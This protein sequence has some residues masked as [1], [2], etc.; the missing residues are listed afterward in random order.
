MFVYFSV[1]DLIASV[2]LVSVALVSVISYAIFVEPEKYKTRYASPTKEGLAK[3]HTK[4]YW[5]WQRMFWEN[6]WTAKKICEASDTWFQ[7]NGFEG[8]CCSNCNA[9]QNVL[10]GGPGYF[11]ARCGYYNVQC[12]YGG[13][14]PLPCPMY[15]PPA[16]TIRRG[17]RMSKAWRGYMEFTE[18]MKKL[19]KNRG[20]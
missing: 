11:C 2:A 13:L 7:F 4:T 15:G 19:N 5:W 18:K 9:T 16:R 10:C 20:D 12:L 17:I 14:M 3:Y 6:I 1:H 8:N